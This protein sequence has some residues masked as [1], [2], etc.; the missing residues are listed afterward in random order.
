MTKQNKLIGLVKGKFPQREINTYTAN[1]TLK[2]IRDFTSNKEVSKLIDLIGK[3]R[4]YIGIKESLSQ[5]ELF[6]NVTFIRENFNQLNLFDIKQAIDLSINGTLNVDVEH[7]QNFSPLYISKILKSYITYKG[8][9][10]VKLN[11]KISEEKQKLVKISNADKLALTKASI[12]ALYNERDNPN[13]F[14]GGSVTYNFIKRNNLIPI[15]KELVEEAMDYGDKLASSLAKDKAIFEAFSE[16]PTSYKDLKQK[17]EIE[18]RKY[19][20]NYVVIKWLNSLDNIDDFIDTI[21]FSMI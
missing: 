8:E 11:N 7:Y 5:E 13:F 20:R 18:K 21:T 15:T 12:K 2:K 10:I 17:K 14:D 16:N 6:M 4:Y 19:A 1:K 3:W 9:I